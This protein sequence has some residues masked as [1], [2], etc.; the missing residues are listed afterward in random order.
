MSSFRFLYVRSFHIMFVS[1]QPE[2]AMVYVYLGAS[3]K[4]NSFVVVI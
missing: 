2:T 3:E 4:Q 1:L